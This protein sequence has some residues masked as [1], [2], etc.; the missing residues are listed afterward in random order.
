MLIGLQQFHMRNSSMN[1]SFQIMH[2]RVSTHFA[3]TPIA[4]NRHVYGLSVCIALLPRA[5]RLVPGWSCW[6][7]MCRAPCS[8]NAALQW[9]DLG[10]KNHRHI[11][12]R[13]D[14]RSQTAQRGNPEWWCLGVANSSH[15]HVGG[16]LART[17]L[18]QARP[19]AEY[20]EWRTFDCPPQAPIPLEGVRGQDRVAVRG[21]RLSDAL[22]PVFLEQRKTLPRSIFEYELRFGGIP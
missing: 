9:S 17:L 7:I 5:H 20:L 21:T 8:L 1:S 19:H 3:Y 11:L 6:G 22:E 12:P 18:V 13:E 4:N 14:P 15:A 10:L 2:L 16:Q